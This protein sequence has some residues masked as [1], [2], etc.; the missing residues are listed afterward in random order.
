[1]QRA[2][3]WALLVARPLDFL[4]TASRPAVWLP[5]RATDLLV[6][7]TGADPRA[8]R[9]EVSIEEIRDMI[10]ARRDFSPDQRTIISG[11][12][13]ITERVLREI[14]VPGRDVVTVPADAPVEQAL[15]NLIAAGH[16]RAPSPLPTGCPR[17]PSGHDGGVIIG[18]RLVAGSWCL[19]LR[20]RG[21][22]RQEARG[23]SSS[24][25]WAALGTRPERTTFSSTTRPGV[26][27]T[28]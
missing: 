5:G 18:T 25:T 23:A 16:S 28:P 11:A 12:F 24:R 8:A 7:L 20:L 3:G 4:A 27:M 9:D 19:R 13:E 15:H 26:D 17:P 10:A 6:R 14:L 21:R 2:E 1:M 22:R